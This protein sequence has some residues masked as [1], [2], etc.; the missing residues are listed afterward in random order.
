[1]ALTVRS[2]DYLWGEKKRKTG[3][4]KKKAFSAAVCLLL[5]CRLCL[6]AESLHQ[7]CCVYRGHGTRKSMEGGGYGMIQNVSLPLLLSGLLQHESDP[8]KYNNTV[9]QTPLLHRRGS[10]CTPVHVDHATQGWVFWKT[11]WPP[12]KRTCGGSQMLHCT[13]S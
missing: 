3:K 10:G 12:L 9:T 13:D 7:L 2:C 8:L 6:W 4:I 1:M 5:W 11:A